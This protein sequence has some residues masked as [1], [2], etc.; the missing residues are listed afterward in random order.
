MRELLSLSTYQGDRRL[1]GGGIEAQGSFWGRMRV[2]QE[3]MAF[4][5]QIM[6]TFVLKREEKAEDRGKGIRE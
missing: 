6:R 3:P 2:E 5:G 4:R 1:L